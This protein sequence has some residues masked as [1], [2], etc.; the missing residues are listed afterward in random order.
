MPERLSQNLTGLPDIS[1]EPL[2]LGIHQPEDLG[3]GAAL[4]GSLQHAVKGLGVPVLGL[5]LGQ[6]E[7]QALL[8]LQLLHGIVVDGPGGSDCSAR[9]C[10]LRVLDPHTLHLLGI[11]LVQPHLDRYL[12][13][14][15]AYQGKTRLLGLL[16]LL[17]PHVTVRRDSVCSQGVL[18]TSENDFDC[19]LVTLGLLQLGGGHPDT[20][21]RGHMLTCLVQHLLCILVWT[22]LC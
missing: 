12:D 20:G 19:F 17:E 6:P 15:L 4:H 18:G 5:E 11:T 7:P 1:L 10:G 8:A 3:V 14:G 2:L 21:V 22:Q 13:N 16:G 9:D